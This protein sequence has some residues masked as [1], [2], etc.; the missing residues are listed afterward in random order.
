MRWTHA[1]EWGSSGTRSG[2]VAVECRPRSRFARC[3]VLMVIACLGAA[4]VGAQ[5][6]G[7]PPAAGTPSEAKPQ[8]RDDATVESLFVDFLH[9][10][11]LGRFTAANAYAEALLRHP[12]LDPRELLALSGKHRKSMQTLL[13]LVQNTEV[14]PNA[15]KVIELIEQGQLLERKDDARILSNIALL[16]GEPQQ[17][18]DAVRHLIQSG[19]YAI[20]HLVDALHD[21]TRRN[22][23][24]RILSALPKIGRDAVRP[25]VMALHTSREDV[26]IELV[27]ALGEIGYPSAVPYLLKLTVDPQVADATRQAAQAAVGRIAALSGRTSAT[28]APEAFHE[29]AELYYNEDPSVAADPRLDLANV[30]YWNEKSRRVER[31][32]VETTIFGQVM[33]MRCAEEALLLQPD[34]IESI[35]LWLAANIRRE[36][37]LGMDVESG[38][39]GELGRADA[40]RPADWPRAL[41]F[42]QA[43]GPRFA[44][45]VLD[46][47][48]RDRDALV[49]LG[50]IEALRITAGP[51]SLIGSETYKQPLVKALQFPD[52][53]V[54]IRA[55]LALG[56]ALPTQPFSDS[57]LVIPV[58]SEALA[59]TGQRRAL[60]VAPDEN[61]RNRI[62]GAVRGIDSQ[63]I[64][65]ASF[66][67]GLSRARR[68]L[69]HLSAIFV[70]TDITEPDL[71]TAMGDLRREF[72]FS[73]T[74]VVILTSSDRRKTA[75][76]V[77]ASDPFTEQVDAQA[78]AAAL[79]A[80][81][82]RIVARTGQKPLDAAAAVEI[83]LQAARTLE[84]IAAHGRT[85]FDVTGAE[86]ALIADL[87]S[88]SEELRA[89]CAEVLARIPTPTAQR[90][91]AYVAMDDK[92]SESLRVSVFGSLARSA[93]LA[94]NQ[95]E[96]QQV[97]RLLDIAK[98]EPS[99]ILRTAASQALGALNLADNQASAII[100]SFYRG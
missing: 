88:T 64:A 96:P 38:D 66:Y 2:G 5:T 7:Q 99:L 65:E 40:T 89:T 93:R 80:A 74:P 45:L 30:W 94:G 69:E 20:P 35:G 16:G 39:P 49:A 37:R 76:D 44:H 22:L 46:R 86:P 58:L 70:S 55:A 42:S 31:T 72:Q 83:A 79:S 41:Y 15:A 62:A 100:R 56:A 77:T 91:I 98:N 6:T 97:A 8:I 27:R 21:D 48:V 4:T 17:E 54:R 63:A 12:N 11:T 28:T 26:R 57:D 33:A 90:S 43:A 14:G 1:R 84:A 23:H 52:L 60:V 19:E 87:S 59:Q 78:D 36:G 51:A 25:L 92:N 67:T 3:A 68:E 82:E 18:Y 73:K 85:V 9:F 53:L 95:L 32:E 34:R 13:I 50:A 81:L 61:H 71:V 29:L 24:R 47:A 75:D 10:A